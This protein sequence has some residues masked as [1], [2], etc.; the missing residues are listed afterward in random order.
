M[1]INPSAVIL[2]YARDPEKWP[3][4]M[5]LTRVK[6]G[7][8]KIVISFGLPSSQPQAGI[9][10]HTPVGISRCLFSSLEIPLGGEEPFGSFRLPFGFLS[11]SFPL[12]DL[13]LRPGGVRQRPRLD[14]GAGDTGGGRGVASHGTPESFKRKWIQVASH[15]CCGRWLLRVRFGVGVWF[16]MGHGKGAPAF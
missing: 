9:L 15:R 16:L 13:Q 6:T 12:E 11:A 8:P 1:G 10:T 5:S 2:D 14:G 3:W 7:H 4:D